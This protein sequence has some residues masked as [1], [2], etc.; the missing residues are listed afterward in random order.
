MDYRSQTRNIN[1]Q[2]SQQLL[3]GRRWSKAMDSNYKHPISSAGLP[4][5]VTYEEAVRFKPSFANYL[6]KP[7][8]QTD[9]SKILL[10]MK[11]SLFNCSAKPLIHWVV[12]KDTVDKSRIT[13]NR[14]LLVFLSAFSF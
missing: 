6:A 2:T 1:A 7:S 4:L 8:P 3:L 11:I 13:S 14:F 10:I 9:E 12:P 5:L